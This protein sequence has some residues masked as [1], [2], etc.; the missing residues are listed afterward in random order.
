MNGELVEIC[1]VLIGK[2]IRIN[3]ICSA[4]IATYK[5]QEYI[6]FRKQSYS[7]MTLQEIQSQINT[8]TNFL[9]LILNQINRLETQI[10]IIENKRVVEEEED[11]E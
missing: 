11:S 5:I 4:L 8:L 6:W 9:S 1:G 7:R 10:R 2:F 3:I